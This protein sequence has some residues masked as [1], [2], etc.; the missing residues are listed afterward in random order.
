M[1]S[2]EFARRTLLAKGMVVSS[3]LAGCSSNQQTTSTEP[4]TES[5]SSTETATATV[6][7]TPSKPSLESFEYPDGAQKDGISGSTLNESHQRTVMD[8]GSATVEIDERTDHGD[9]IDTLA[10]SNFY[11]AES[12]L[13]TEQQEEVTEH[14]WSPP[15]GPPT[16]VQMDSGFEQRYRIDNRRLQ[17]HEALRFDVLRSVAVGGEWSG[18]QEVVETD[19]GNYAVVYESTGV[20]IESMLLE[21]T[22][23]Q[24]ISEFS[25]SMTV[26]EQG[27][28]RELSYEMTVETDR[29]PV[30][31]R[32]TVTT[33][34]VGETTAAEPSWLNTAKENGVRFTAT[35][36]DDR[37]FVKMDMDNGADVPATTRAD[38]S[39]AGHATGEIDATVSE[40][41]TLYLGISTSGDLLS[42]VNSRPSGGIELG[43]FVYANLVDGA[44]D[45]F[46]G[47]V[48]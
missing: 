1:S 12:V 24:A 43:D 47:D 19:A 6:T 40:G 34:A 21:V 31:E 41:D 35:T 38:V 30:Q 46:E 25:A 8:A 16:Y 7:E 11:S 9:F 3:M 48:R 10:Q 20:V 39:A 27:H 18:A 13:Q 5:A 17:P 2:D 26:S 32:S 15:N 33:S 22:V 23:G 45:F 28:V 37:T 42:A 44:F 29:G 4:K 36:T 14:R